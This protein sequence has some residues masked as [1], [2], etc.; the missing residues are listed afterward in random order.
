MSLLTLAVMLSYDGRPIR[1]KQMRKTSV[2][3]Y[4]SGRSL[5]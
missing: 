4:D 1:E 2:W 3:G 5:S